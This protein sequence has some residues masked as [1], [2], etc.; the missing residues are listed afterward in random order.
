MNR[1]GVTVQSTC[2]SR[3]V[4]GIMWSERWPK[5]FWVMAT[6]S[7]VDRSHRWRGRG[8]WQRGLTFAWILNLQ[9][10]IINR[11]NIENINWSKDSNKRI[12]WHLKFIRKWRTGNDYL[13]GS[14]V[15]QEPVLVSRERV[16][17]PALQ[18]LWVYERHRLHSPH[19]LWKW[20]KILDTMRIK[21]IN[22]IIQ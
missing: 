15:V 17:L 2:D 13:P 1:F 12:I 21:E 4:G 5:R 8:R 6:S 16:F 22:V 3:R 9:S 11:V 14:F 20:Q 7:G 18:A 10:T 19:V